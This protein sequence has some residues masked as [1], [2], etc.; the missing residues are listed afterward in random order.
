MTDEKEAK[1][2][3]ESETKKKKT[4]KPDEVCNWTF[5]NYDD[6]F[7]TA[8][9]SRFYFRPGKAVVDITGPCP[10]CGKQIYCI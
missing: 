3:P 6:H 4:K 5:H 8:C 2:Q 1:T 10:G 7:S 9:R